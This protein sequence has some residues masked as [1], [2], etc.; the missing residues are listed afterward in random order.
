MKPASSR[1]SAPSLPG[2]QS[3]YPGVAVARTPCGVHAYAEATFLF[4]HCDGDV[5]QLTAVAADCCP[6]TE[7][8]AKRDQLH[9]GLGSKQLRPMRNQDQS[10]IIVM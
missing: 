6:A 3:T 5:G 4:L 9:P 10:I 1:P 7:E 8:K 2:K